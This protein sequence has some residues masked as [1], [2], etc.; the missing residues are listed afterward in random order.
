MSTK[1]EPRQRSLNTV[2]NTIYI[3]FVAIVIIFSIVFSSITT[4]KEVRDTTY[5]NVEST[6]SDKYAVLNRTFNQLFEQVVNLNNNPNLLEVIND[7]EDSL[8]KA[9]SMKT[10]IKELYYR[11]QDVLSSI[12][13]NV[14]DGE[15]FFNGGEIN[16]Q[17]IDYHKFFQYTNQSSDYV[18]LDA[19]NNPFS[20]DTAP[21]FSICKTI[22][23]DTSEVSGVI[24]FNFRYEYIQQILREGHVS[25]NGQL[26]L[27]NEGQLIY[28]LEVDFPVS[29]L[30]D[31]SD[32]KEVKETDKGV[33][34]LE[35][36]QFPINNWQLAAI[37]PNSDLQRSQPAYLV[38][39][40]ALFVFL[41]LAGTV[42]V[43]V[44]GRF[45]SKPI[46]KLAKEIEETS[47]TEDS[48]GE[49]L[50]TKPRLKEM[51]VLY[52]SFNF[53]IEKN[54]RL[55]AENAKTLEERSHLEIELLQTQIN[56]H[57]LYNTLYS[58]QSLSDMKMN[59]DASAMTRSLAEFY[60]T[61][62]SKGNSII[63]LKDEIEHVENYLT[64]MAYRYGDRFDY[65]IEVEDA[66]LLKAPIPKVSL[67]PIVENSIYHGLKELDHFGHL[68]IS[69][70]EEHG[71][72]LMTIQDNGKGISEEQLQKI[73]EEINLPASHE[74]K[75][76][77]IGLRS[78][79]LRIRNYFGNA[80]GLWV[81]YCEAGAR[82]KVAI[83]KEKKN[84]KAINR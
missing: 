71:T 37:F 24:V 16:V 66:A 18:W 43:V 67:Q 58:I 76:T 81:E 40:V 52:D 54:E 61:G 5:A 62:I 13:I 3:A 42:M 56:P 7:D 44:V 36:R 27:V 17:D 79:N 48:Q 15:F 72:V 41:F 50:T 55:L 31:L 65:Q 78:V 14:N 47:L 9:V 57:F 28:P 51:G 2:L 83:P 22:G 53:M 49:M 74:R 77:G 82:I 19:T 12:Y 84:E 33:Y 80:Y 20:T 4:T 60:R 63:S 45:I 6:L 35:S 69:V 21:A 59:Q 30:A 75:V 46:Q 64:I 23:D 29:T 8:S 26:V 39:A 32:G 68:T 73:N 11:F 10:T 34:H 25:E 38:L 1:K 70:K